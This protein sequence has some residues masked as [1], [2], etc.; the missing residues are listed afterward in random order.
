MGCEPVVLSMAKST[1]CGPGSPGV[2]T[3]PAPP[4][5]VPELVVVPVPVVLVVPELVD[6][7]PAPPVLDDVEAEVPVVVVEGPDED[8]EEAPAPP[9]PA[10]VDFPALPPQAAQRD[11]AASVAKPRSTG[12][13]CMYGTSG[14]H[15]SPSPSRTQC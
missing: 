10:V 2:T 7:P 3:V 8:D 11:R 15:D 6:I 14:R 4:A 9:P 12:G 13:R 1:S 5:P